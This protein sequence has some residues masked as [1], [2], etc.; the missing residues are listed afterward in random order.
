MNG[1]RF[2][3]TATRSWARFVWSPATGVSEASGDCERLLGIQ[4]RALVESPDPVRLLPAGLSAALVSAIPETPTL[5]GLGSLLFTLDP[6]PGGTVVTVFEPVE[7]RT[8]GGSI[9]EEI[10]TGVIGVD[11]SG[12]IRLWN[13]AMTS[14]IPVKSEAALGR[15]I[16]SLVPAPLLFAWNGVLNAVADGRTIRAELRPGVQRRVEAVFSPGG[17]GMIGVFLDTSDGFEAERRLRSARRMNQTYFQSISSG[18]V[19][20]GSDLRILVSNRAFGRIFGVREGLPGMPVYEVLPPESFASLDQAVRRIQAGELEVPS[21][22]VGF[23]MPGGER[24][25]VSQT[26]RPVRSEDDENLHIVGIFEDITDRFALADTV[27]RNTRKT[28]RM[29]ELVDGLG[30]AEPSAMSDRVVSSMVEIAGAQAAALFKPDRH[31]AGRLAASYGDWPFVLPD[32]FLELRIPRAAWSGSQ[33]LCLRVDE[34]RQGVGADSCLDVIPI[35]SGQLQRGFLVLLFDSQEAAQAFLVEAS[36]PAFLI[37]SSLEAAIRSARTELVETLLEKEKRFSSD[38][39]GGIGIPAAVFGEDWRVLMWNREMS[40]ITGLDADSARKRP[41]AVTELLFAPMGGIAEARKLASTPFSPPVTWAV[42]HPDG[43]AAE[44]SWRISRS[45]LAEKDAT[46]TVSILSG[47]RLGGQIE[48]RLEGRRHE[49]AMLLAGA[50]S[51][52]SYAASPRQFATA[53][54]DFAAAVTG[55]SGAT[56]ALPMH[57]GVMEARAGRTREDRTIS[58][59]IPAA[60]GLPSSPARLDLTGDASRRSLDMIS[61]IASGA[62]SGSLSCSLGR[63]LLDEGVPT[64]AATV[65]FTDESGMVT[66]PGLVN[67]VW[68]EG[69]IHVAR[70]L[71]IPTEDVLDSVRSAALLGGVS[72]GGGSGSAPALRISPY[73]TGDAVRFIWHADPEAVQ[74]GPAVW[75][76]AVRDLSVWL[77]DRLREARGR[78]SALSH[79]LGRENPVRPALM[80]L[81][82]DM[83]S[84]AR[85]SA[86]LGFLGRALLASPSRVPASEVIGLVVQKCIGKGRRPPDLDMGSDS[87]VV[88]ADI[89]LLSDLIEASMSA[90]GPGSAPSVRIGRSQGGKADGPSIHQGPGGLAAFEILW[91]RPIARIIP[92]HEA[93]ELAAGGTMSAS[94]ELTLVSVA[95]GLAGCIFEADA[96]RIRI[97]TPAAQDEESW[98]PDA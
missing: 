3:E 6:S 82:L 48:E 25:V 34:L 52:L 60:A 58:V 77:P 74:D 65:L 70:L 9:L 93:V 72:L 24:R 91:D 11:A 56:A 22:S 51:R 97:V 14:I 31:G 88:R 55:A 35:G 71:G 87:P 29:L 33:G 27:E 59:Q 28:G 47:I 95:A 98:G 49:D 50:V 8:R 94:A 61:S 90:G 12:I 1:D 64:A 30:R 57:E 40:E 96:N 63:G 5:A 7:A 16:D 38:L 39:L 21:S 4:A 80:S 75:L 17:P 79:V 2:S 67:G 20:L 36:I 44:C 81:L 42:R 19:M 83:S 62:L 13:S 68:V 85:V 32:D 18:L 69:G 45:E 86:H 43:S 84:L 41:G 89:E 23:C 66:S 73:H 37:G 10:G 76:K 92:Q 15:P 26:F 53:L 46:E 54:A 78:L